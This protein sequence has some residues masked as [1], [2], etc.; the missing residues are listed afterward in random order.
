MWVCGIKV[1]ATNSDMPKIQLIIILA[2]ITYFSTLGLDVYAGV[3]A[4]YGGLVSLVNTFLV[5]RHI[6][7]QKNDVTISAQAG[8]WM[9]VISIVMRMAMVVSLTLIGRFVFELNADAL[10]IGLILGLI[11]FLTDKALQK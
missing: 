2:S 8:V 11:G 1:L 7:K 6:R 4:F 5:D 10:I 9:M 3:S